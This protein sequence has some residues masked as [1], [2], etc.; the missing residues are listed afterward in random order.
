M[1]VAMESLLKL[2]RK[3]P[4][5]VA[6]P[7][8]AA[9]LARRLAGPQR[10]RLLQGFPALPLMERLPSARPLAEEQAGLDPTRG[11]IVGVLPHPFCNPRVR[12]CGF[13]TFPQG[14]Y[15]AE[16]AARCVGAVIRELQG[17]ARRCEGISGRRV[18]ALYFGGATAN[19]TPVESFEELGRALAATFDLAGAEVT[20]EGVPAYFL[21]RRGVL[22]DAFAGVPARQRRLSMGVQ[23]FD[24]AWRERMGRGGF[25]GPAEVAQVVAEAHARGWTTSCDL[26]VNLPGQPREA[27]V[28]DV[29]TAAAMG[30]DQVC[31]YHLVLHEGLGTEWSR[32]PALLA[33]RPDNETAFGSWSAA[34]ERLLED[35]FVQTTLT[36]FERADV[37]ASERRFRYEDCSFRPER[38]DGLG[39]GPAGITTI[40]RGDRAVKLV[41]ATDAEEYVDLVHRRVGDGFERVFRYEPE[42]VRLLHVTRTLA[43]GALD[44]A[45]YRARFG[46]DVVADHAPAFDALVAAR[47]VEVEADV[48]RLTPRGLFFADSVAGLL[49]SRRAEALRDRPDLATGR[50]WRA[51][52]ES[53]MG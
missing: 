21:G 3:R 13:C 53:F 40:T 15:G 34:R 33:A 8:P 25:G 11:L 38:F 27:M 31:V 49:A 14:R 42:D 43:R 22:L 10:H 39:F 4:L 44:R 7:S 24:A 30:F 45:T 26:L 28:E 6:V 18:E 5:E 32:D 36:N 52:E 29:R 12:G 23:T 41:N 46:R 19:L 37:H 50:P 51:G 2:F 1:E 20:L 17:R 48:V 9:E 47:L 35:G 16:R